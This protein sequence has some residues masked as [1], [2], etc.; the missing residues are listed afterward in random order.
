MFVFVHKASFV[1]LKDTNKMSAQRI[2]LIKILMF[3]RQT[4]KTLF[5]DKGLFILK[6]CLSIS[7]QNHKIIEDK[8]YETKLELWINRKIAQ[9]KER[10]IER[11]E[12]SN[13]L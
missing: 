3:S 8:Q 9:S 13:K 11:K 6:K 2:E 7:L 4:W 1:W 10:K 12:K 5:H